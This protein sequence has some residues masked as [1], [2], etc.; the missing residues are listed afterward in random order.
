[1]VTGT[2]D[3]MG[4]IT[5]TAAGGVVGADEG[6]AL[7]L[8]VGGPVGA[9]VCVVM[10]DIAGS[11]INDAVYQGGK[12]IVKTAAKVIESAWESTK[13]VAEGMFNRVATWLTT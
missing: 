7:G 10:G 8:A 1:M 9:F 4:N 3:A 2:L 12:A 5:R 6:A 11:A 13:A